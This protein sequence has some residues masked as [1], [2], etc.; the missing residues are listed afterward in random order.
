MWHII[1][2]AYSDA[3]FVV[4]SALLWMLYLKNNI[5]ILMNMEVV[6]LRGCN[7]IEA[8]VVLTLQTKER[9]IAVLKFPSYIFL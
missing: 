3:Q 2:L 8:L 9:Y 1:Y 4:D 7:F 5:S 6:G